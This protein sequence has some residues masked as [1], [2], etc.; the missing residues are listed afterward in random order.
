[1]HERIRIADLAA[2]VGLSGSQLGRLFR[3][4]TGTTPAAYLQQLRMTR[5]R[6][7]IERSSLSV[8]EVMAQVGIADPSHFARD[9]RLAHGFS[10]R[11]LRQQLRING[12][13]YLYPPVKTR[14]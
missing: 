12:P 9:F 14:G 4:D 6:M 8:S 13:S 11:T 5:A 1:M 3:R 7:L 10:P 2:A